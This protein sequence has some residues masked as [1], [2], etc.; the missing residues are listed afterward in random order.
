M[1]HNHGIVTIQAGM[2]ANFV[3]THWWNMQEASFCYDKDQAALLDINHDILFREGH[4]YQQ[5]ITFTPRLLCIDLKENFRGIRG[6]NL[7]HE[8]SEI[9]AERLKNANNEAS[10]KGTNERLVDRTQSDDCYP[11]Q[12]HLN[13]WDGRFEVKTLHSDADL[14]ESSSF[15]ADQN[16][17][18]DDQHSLSMPIEIYDPEKVNVEAKSN[19]TAGARCTTDICWCHCH[20]DLPEPKSEHAPQ[21]WSTFL[22][23]SLHPKSPC[24]IDEYSLNDSCNP[25][26][27]YGS[28]IQAYSCEE[29]RNDVE[30]KLRWYVEECDYLQGF[31]ILIDSYNGF[32]GV[33]DGILQH[34]DDEYQKKTTL[35]FPVL[36]NS[37]PLH[38]QDTVK[39]MHILRLY[40]T[41]LS[42]S[43]LN[44]YSSIFSP[45]TLNKDLLLFETPY[46]FFPYTHLNPQLLYHSSA[47]LAGALE[48][49]T[50]PYRLKARQFQ[51]S[52]IE[53]NTAL[54]G[55][56]LL[57]TSV[58]FPFPVGASVHLNN[59]VN[60][61]RKPEWAP[62]SLTPLSDPFQYKTL[63]QSV[64]L[65]G[66]PENMLCSTRP[67][68]FGKISAEDLVYQFV[69]KYTPSS[70]LSMCVFDEKCKVT[71]P[72]PNFFCLRLSSSGYVSDHE[73]PYST[74]VKNIPVASFLGN[75]SGT[76]DLL[77]RLLNQAE[78]LNLK[79]YARNEDP[80][81]EGDDFIEAIQNLQCLKDCYGHEYS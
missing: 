62:S 72:F 12:R 33:A 79:S 10:F 5:E 9:S 77:G 2:Y 50:A 6:G 23:T 54:Y 42:F 20:N 4:N 81:V 52:D 61:S 45:L 24:L 41:L 25:L 43:G 28:G 1:S 68:A 69:Q 58:C 11:E 51:M 7:Y 22:N 67:T 49:V 26:D 30:D 53:K 31:Q 76:S 55:R 65:R 80:F 14:G 27:V 32:A 78:K 71:P 38:T 35:C 40:S 17:Q 59:M 74:G 13:M 19:F 47:V 3:G 73:R 39:K 66:V 57:S 36:Q 56:K 37:Y 44:S 60:S 64:V 15:S 75:S 18:E 16:F 46:T 29:S 34:L 48:S 70:V 63:S 21:S 8:P